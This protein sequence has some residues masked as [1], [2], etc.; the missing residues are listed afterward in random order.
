MTAE[1]H[2]RLTNKGRKQTPEWIKKRITKTADAKRGK[3]Y[4]KRIYENPRFIKSGEGSMTYELAKRL[5]EAGFPGSD[6]WHLDKGELHYH[7]EEIGP[8]LSEL[9]EACGNGFFG[10]NRLEKD[11]WSCHFME[12]ENASGEPV[13]KTPE[14][15][16]A[17]LWLELNKGIE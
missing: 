4:P 3:K 13:Y 10:L 1:E 7:P 9:I 11:Q 2:Q 16:V 12:D 15:A 6:Q 5:R 17:N 14:E 8:T